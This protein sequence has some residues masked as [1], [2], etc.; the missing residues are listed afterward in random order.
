MPKTK[1]QASEEDHNH[2]GITEK[3]PKEPKR[4]VP[5]LKQLA[6]AKITVQTELT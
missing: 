5:K 4:F 3:L 6:K 1:N 2:C